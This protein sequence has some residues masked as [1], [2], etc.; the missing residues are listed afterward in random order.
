MPHFVQE[1]VHSL[2]DFC[3]I[4][5]K[6][7]KE[8]PI[9]AY[10]IEVVDIIAGLTFVAGSTCFLP[11]FSVDVPVFLI[12]CY[13]FIG[14]SI[15]YFLVCLFCFVEALQEKGRGTFEVWENALY[16]LG[17]ALFFIGTFLYMP[18]QEECD[19]FARGSKTCANIAQE[20]NR[21]DEE[22]FGSVLFAVGSVIFAIAAFLNAM[23]QR[24]YD[25]WTHNML[26]IITFCYLFGSILFAMGSVCFLPHMGCEDDMLAVGAWMFIIGSAAF[27]FGACF[28]LWRTIVIYAN[29]EDNDES[30][31]LVE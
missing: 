29:E 1:G 26:S 9:G 27:L 3:V 15:L 31:K 21:Y 6:T 10:I 11:V 22:F 23:G 8:F 24:Q 2:A 13:L 12:G 20:V 5:V 28:S 18:E 7:R 25:Q 19:E 16:L 17:C 30:A 14:G 4:R